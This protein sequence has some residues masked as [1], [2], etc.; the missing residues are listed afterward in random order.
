VEPAVGANRVHYID[1]LRVIAVLLLV[2][3]HSARVFDIWE[4]FYAKNPQTS[5]ALSWGLIAPV[6]VWHMPLLFLLAGASTWF[7]LRK[8]PGWRYARERLLRLGVPLV[9]GS[10]LIVPPQAWFGA[11]TNAGYRG[12]MI[13]YLTSP[14][15]HLDLTKPDY[16]GLVS[17]G[18]LW[19]ILYL[20]IIALALAPLLT[21]W[22]RRLDQGGAA[23]SEEG[24]SRAEGQPVL[25][26]LTRRLA[27][28]PGGL[29]AFA[30]P[31]IVADALPDVGGKNLF[32]FVV[33]F[34]LGWLL[35][36]SGAER[37]LE[38]RRWLWL[39]LAA[40]GMIAL[41]LLVDL[42]SMPDFTLGRGA[43]VLL[44]Y[45]TAVAVVLAALGWGG[46]LL[47]RDHPAL[48]FAAEAS[49]P[50]YILHQTVI[51]ALGFS[52]V[53]LPW[54]VAAKYALLVL[55]SLGATLAIY[56]VAIR[57]WAPVRFLFG[58]RP[59]AKQAT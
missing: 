51:V 25:V 27:S 9:V 53:Q 5:G 48:H 45:A 58:M 30:L 54:G 40:A 4:P 52:I 37:T 15:W 55:A 11:M 38:Q 17:P 50:F 19:F 56:D 16:S 13:S 39:A 24:A 31:L 7:A 59:L 43:F 33:W 2:P 14:A 12:G 35:F 49:Y 6:D 47:D 18:H 8:R 36:A 23:G 46:R 26:A 21:M 20:L 32:V 42:G 3:F 10:L 28:T 57:P 41:P 34:L 1:W 29:L 22:H 44:K